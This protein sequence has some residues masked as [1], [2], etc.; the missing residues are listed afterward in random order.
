MATV[1]QSQNGPHHDSDGARLLP[2]AQWS[3]AFSGVG[4]SW[5]F[6]LR[7]GPCANGC[8]RS[9]SGVPVVSSDLTCLLPYMAGEFSRGHPSFFV[10]IHRAIDGYFAAK[11]RVRMD[12][13]VR[14]QMAP[15][16]SLD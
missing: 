10:E 7:H 5:T 11:P 4:R 1:S 8:L 3:G 13:P 9:L 16:D 12:G 2:S 6:G 14:I 15:A